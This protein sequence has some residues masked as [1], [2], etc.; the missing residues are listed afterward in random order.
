MRMTVN[1][2]SSRGLERTDTHREE[3]EED[4]EDEEE[5]E[6][7]LQDSIM[8][9]LRVLELYSGIGGMHWALKGKIVTD[10]VQQNLQTFFFII[11]K[12]YVLI[13][14]DIEQ[15]LYLS[16][17][18]CRDVS[19]PLFFFFLYFFFFSPMNLDSQQVKCK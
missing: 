4:D 15:P 7:P 18:W 19:V 11:I 8:A 17:A 5:E 13:S 3:E 16:H 10:K 14:T 2:L 6:L 9:C 1:L 12:S